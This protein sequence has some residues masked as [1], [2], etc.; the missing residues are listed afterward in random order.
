L[1][2]PKQERKKPGLDAVH[3]GREARL[4]GRFSTVTGRAWLIV[5]AGLLLSL[6]V[7]RITAGSALERRRTALLAKQRAIEATVGKDWTPLRDRIEKFVLD[8]GGAFDAEHVEPEAK[9]WVNHVATGVYLRMRLADAKSVE[10]I[11]SAARDSTKDAFTGC[12]LRT[13]N[14]ALAKGEVDAG[15]FPDQPW[16]LRQAY[17]AARILSP[18]WST[19][20]K[21]AEDS[22]RLRV[23]EQQYDKAE[24]EEIPRAIDIIKRADFFLLVLDEAADDPADEKPLWADGG[25][26][27]A[28][29]NIQLA[30][31]WA[32]VYV[33]DLQKEKEIVRLRQHAEGKFIFA[34]GR[35]VT[36][37]ETLDAMKRQVNNCK[38]AQDVRSAVLGP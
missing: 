25:I 5:A 14:Q 21:E 37:D 17:A 6:A 15:A 19:Q 16:N 36:D 33:L 26:D 2:Q 11:R 18:D 30:P 12:L 29:E 28:E 31:H 8:R 32:R 24:S 22:I 38:L 27:T 13:E 10:S 35:P 7:Y 9:A 20:V 3:K 23:F 4:E 1:V 34:G